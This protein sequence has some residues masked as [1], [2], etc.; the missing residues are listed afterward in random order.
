MNNTL[1]FVLLTY[2]AMHSA[3]VL[4]VDLTGITPEDIS[5]FYNY[6]ILLCKTIF[7]VLFGLNL[8]FYATKLFVYIVN[9]I[10]S[11]AGAR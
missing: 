9:V 3:N 10:L 7:S 5:L 6:L 2:F 1:R 11:A 4:S 8:L